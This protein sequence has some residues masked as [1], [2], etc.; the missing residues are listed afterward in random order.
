MSLAFLIREVHNIAVF[1]S[2]SLSLYVFLS[3]NIL[4]D[5]H[6]NA[7]N[8]IIIWSRN[9]DLPVISFRHACFAPHFHEIQLLS[10]SAFLPLAEC[11][12]FLPW[13][14]STIFICFSTIG[15]ECCI[16]SLKILTE[17]PD[18]WKTLFYFRIISLQWHQDLSPSRIICTNTLQRAE[19]LWRAL[20]LEF[21][22]LVR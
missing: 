10:T 7:P 21:K 22:C 5:W 17:I 8:S 6:N 9:P 4:K 18:F 13:S 19:M 3:K 15:F 14:S 16:I 20:S 12:K 11:A 2:L 1:V